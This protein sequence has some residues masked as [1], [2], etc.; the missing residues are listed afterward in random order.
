MTEAFVAVPAAGQTGAGI[1]VLHAWW[2][3]NRTFQDLC[4]RLAAD[5][6][7]ALAPDLY[8]DGAVATTVQEAET[9]MQAAEG[10]TMRTRA[11]S[12]LDQ[13]LSHPAV[14]GRQ[15][16]V[17]GFS[18]GAAWA[19]DLAKRRPEV[20]AAVVFYGTMS[21]DFTT[22]HAAFLGHFAP[23]DE[24]EPDED[25]TALETSIKAAGRE[26]EFHRYPGTRHW[27]FEPDRPEYDAAA[28]ELAWARTIA[29]LREHVGPLG[30]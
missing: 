20:A 6:F 2:G 15:V 11:E 22:S 7:V 4:D 29:F 23:G 12:A 10:A 18:M 3:L 21:G 1:L 24:W 14:I 19:L 8:G 5:G 13:L 25:V 28:A 9:Q 17:I 30:S 26:G 16:G 27:F